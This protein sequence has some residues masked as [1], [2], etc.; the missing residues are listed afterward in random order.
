[1]QEKVLEIKHIPGKVLRAGGTAGCRRHKGVT[2]TDI[3]R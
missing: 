1:M 2:F 3:K